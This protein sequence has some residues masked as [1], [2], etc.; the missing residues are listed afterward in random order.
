MLRLAGDQV[1]SLFDALLPVEIREPPAELAALDRL[2]AVRGCWHR[3]S[4]RG[5]RLP[6]IMVDRRSRWPAWCD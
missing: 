5:N 1:E 3:S 6:A 4:G 2:L